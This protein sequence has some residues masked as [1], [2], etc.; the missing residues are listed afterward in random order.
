MTEVDRP[1]AASAARWREYWQESGRERVTE[2]LRTTC[3]FVLI[4]QAAFIGLDRW[5]YPEL[6]APF[7]SMRMAVN[8]LLLAVLFRTRFTFPAA[9]QIAVP[10]AVA[11]EVL[12]MVY[13]TGGPHSYYYPGL[14]LVFV[15]MPVLQ[16]LRGVE[17]LAISGV[18]CAGYAVTPLFDPSPIQWGQFGISL[19]FIC[20]GAFESV[21]SCSALTRARLQEFEQRREIERARD[22][23]KQ[24]D[25]EKSRFTANVHHE[26][27]TPLTLTLAPLEGML[28]GEFGE[29][30]E[31]QRSYLKT[32]HT[33]ALRLLKLINNLLD[34]AKIEGQ[35]LRITR[36]P[37]RLD[38]LVGELLDGARPL[39]E[40]KGVELRSRGLDSLP[41]L[42][43]DREALEKVIVNLLGNALKFTDPGGAIEIRGEPHGEG[44]AHLVV[45]DSGAGIP[46]DQLSRI[47][48]RF[49]QVDSSGSRRYEGTGIGLSLTKELVELHG[50]R[51]WA[52]S[53]G[54]G[55]GTQMHVTLPAAEADGDECEEVLETDGRTVG[56][57]S[58]MAAMEGD[59]GVETRDPEKLRLAEMERNVERAGFAAPQAAGTPPDAEVPADAPEILVVEDNA[60]MR[61]LLEFLLARE[62]RVRT[63]RNG[64][65]GLER[66]REAAP[67]LIL[68]DVMMPE[69]TGTEL[70]RAI[71]SDPQTRGIPLMLVTSKAERQMK[72]EG[73]EL[74]ADDY[75]AK[76]FHPRELLARVR[77]LVRLHRLQ[78]EIR[79]RNEEL[80]SSNRELERALAELR[81]AE[82]Q[83]V[84]SERL[85]AV[86]ELAAG[87][88]H[89][90]N[91]PVNYAINALRTLGTS[92][93]ELRGFAARVLALRDADLDADTHR[94]ALRK[95]GE[96]LDVDD[97]ADTL[98]ELLGISVEGMVRT[99]RLVC[100]LRDFAARGGDE[101]RRVD[102][103]AGLGSTLQLVR[104][105]MSQ[106]GVALEAN[107]ARDL[108]PVIGDAGALNQVFLN[109]LKNAAEANEDQG[110]TVSVSAHRGESCVVVEIRD[111]GV[112]I[113]PE[114]QE[115]LYE[116][117]FSTK[118]AG[119]GTGLGLS[120]SRRIV[121]DHGGSIE[122][123]SREGEGTVFRVRLPAAGE[124]EPDRAA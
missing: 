49:A 23:L 53:E 66:A 24:L 51:V 55:C 27:R 65:E 79:E 83:L 120:I 13:A 8:A 22:E 90:V 63:A 2:E 45:A 76:P 116:P 69:M 114:V 58:S 67:D 104:H 113:P 100:D 35:Q 20:S 84:Q 95:L 110:G 40:R 43:A 3:I 62:F 71:K 1:G 60:D 57:G 91:N 122:C 97:V 42:N 10:T 87:V 93:E 6:F 101:H 117:F 56:L 47:F 38:A 82:V 81:E 107:I 64:R 92:I 115:R 5:A 111:T 16:P 94:A 54:P 19:I 9:S 121:T 75:V 106:A 46:A 37:L 4:L 52:E 74:G 85:A 103:A 124:Q 59:I 80:E 41:Q 123:D 14:I 70:C 33:N 30:S 86:G 34:L 7:F 28:S 108:P 99:S 119:R 21:W 96:E 15:G 31:L 102:L 32:M 88:A 44:G 39:A 73:L 48:D 11:A 89:E 112:G 118:E 26:L 77:S 25:R 109:L 98:A 50:G 18:F 36:R 17:A 61:R 72:I 78:G 68:T 12:A 105:T 29:V